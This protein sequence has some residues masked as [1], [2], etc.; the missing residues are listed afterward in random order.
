MI[1]FHVK[2]N[3]VDILLF[4]GLVIEYK[5]HQSW[6]NFDFFV[7]GITVFLLFISISKQD[8]FYENRE[9]DRY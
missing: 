5:R 3:I 4:L 6:T 1:R 8:R 7:F 2:V 9:R